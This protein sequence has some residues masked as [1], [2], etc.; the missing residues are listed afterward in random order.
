MKPPWRWRPP[1]WKLAPKAE[2]LRLALYLL[3]LGPRSTALPTC[4]EEEYPVGAQCCPKCSPGYHVK[5]TCGELTG[6]VCV[7]CHP[8]TYTTHHNGLS[9]CLQCRVCE[10]AMGLVT[11]R[12]CSST[13]NTVCGCSQGHFCDVRDGDHCI[14][15]RPLTVCRPGQ[16]VLERGTESQDTMCQDCPPGTFSLNGTQEECQPWTR[17]DGAL[18]TEA[19][20]G[21]SST[22]V[23][24]SDRSPFLSFIIVIPIVFILRIVCLHWKRRR[25][26]GD[27]EASFQD[28]T[29]VAVEE[30]APAIPRRDPN[31]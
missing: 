20:P 22:D 30:T 17:C 29:T 16:R 18:E 1:L 14:V 25:S 5:Y 9:E 31:R 8:G 13:E 2:A 24:C 19:K 11:R 6:T 7:P 15:C 12:N 28:V 4:T 10:P 3:L 26:P 27:V 23:T 21:T